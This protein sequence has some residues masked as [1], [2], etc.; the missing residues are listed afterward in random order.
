MPSNTL[1]NLRPYVQVE[2]VEVKG[3]GR[4]LDTTLLV[5]SKPLQSYPS[6]LVIRMTLR[7]AVLIA[8]VFH[9]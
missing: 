5:T 1:E 7:G 8:Y 3:I 6:F 9:P 4:Q 2:I